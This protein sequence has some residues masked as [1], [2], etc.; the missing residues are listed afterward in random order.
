MTIPIKVTIIERQEKENEDIVCSVERVITPKIRRLEDIE[1]ICVGQRAKKIKLEVEFNAY[2]IPSLIKFLQNCEPC[3]NVEE[4]Y[5][6]PN[7]T[8]KIN[9]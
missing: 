9:I 7:S 5:K 1:T 3:F 4:T 6:F 2:L 8:D